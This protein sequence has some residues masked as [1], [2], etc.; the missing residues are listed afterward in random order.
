MIVAEHSAAYTQPSECSAGFSQAASV[1][2][3]SLTLMNGGF[4][5]WAYLVLSGV[6]F[7]R[8]MQSV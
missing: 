7:E 6:L 8:L 5:V 1:D 3:R 2:F 4:R